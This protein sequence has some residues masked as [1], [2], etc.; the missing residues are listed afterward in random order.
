MRESRDSRACEFL[1]VC[2][3]EFASTIETQDAATGSQKQ[4]W[5][6][7][8]GDIREHCCLEELDCEQC[9]EGKIEFR[10]RRY[11][12]ASSMWQGTGEGRLVDMVI[13]QRVLRME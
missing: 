2:L 1:P 12:D 7:G 9:F 11:L 3:V 13:A 4:C 5:S 10:W 8:S 6:L